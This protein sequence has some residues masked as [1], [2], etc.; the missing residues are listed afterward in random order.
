MK[1][2][3]FCYW[4]QG[5]FELAGVQTLSE[6]QVEI[7]KRHLDMTMIH[8]THIPTLGPHVRPAPRSVSSEPVL[9]K[10]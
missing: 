7:I 4:L 1:Y 2:T 3:E 10:C 9:I 6:E 5:F 8:E